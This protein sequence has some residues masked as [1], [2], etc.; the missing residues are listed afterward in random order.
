MSQNPPFE[1]Q[2]G[3]KWL[4]KALDPAGFQQVDLKGMPDQEAHNVVV[5]NYQSQFAV[6]PPAMYNAV[7]TDTSTYESEIYA[8]QDPVVFGV[9]AS[10][11]TGT[12]DPLHDDR[13]ISVKF[14]CQKSGAKS[15]PSITFNST[16]TLF[17]RTC[18][19]FVN[20]QISGDTKAGN[21]YEAFKGFAQ[22]HRVIY[23]ALQAIP[24]CSSQ[25]NS[26]TISVSQQPF[27]GDDLNKQNEEGVGYTCPPNATKAQ[28]TNA[29]EEWG[30]NTYG[31]RIYGKEDFPDTE[32]NI[33]NPASLLTRFAEGAYVPYKLKNPFS[34]DFITSAD[35]TTSIA[36]YWVVGAAYQPITSS[37]DSEAFVPMDWDNTAQCFTS[38]VDPNTG[39]R[40]Q[41]I[42][43]R[44]KLTLMS[45]TGSVKDIIFA[46]LDPT[47]VN[48]NVASLG[49]YT[50]GLNLDQTK[51]VLTNAQTYNP[52]NSV[53]ADCNSRDLTELQFWVDGSPQ[54]DGSSNDVTYCGV[55]R[56]GEDGMPRSR[57]PFSNVAAVLCKS[58][59]MK[60]N[61]TLLFRLGVEIVVTGN[62]VYSP[63]N[64]RSPS[65]DEAAIK[66]Y[67]KVV[68]RLSD[69]FYGNAATD[70]FRE[71]FYN[72]I[73]SQLY[74]PDTSVDF[75]NRGSY[76]RGLVS[77]NQ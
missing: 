52:G 16:G 28:W 70:Q 37:G 47:A 69:G 11:P 48:A 20:T 65:Y 38:K 6:E 5:L 29:Y 9:A 62:S 15:A 32:D 18:K 54:V 50:I 19:K 59:N 17:P 12:V 27:I 73:I 41:V 74:D 61:I 35:A 40:I 25:D 72:Y 55:Y 34:E 46:N 56:C 63:F 58:M 31:V 44:I 71:A 42:C 2:D 75:A 8:F 60:G 23:G 24:T 76:W 3:Q 39:N 64:H 14:G 22:R 36:P 13:N 1:T 77:R 30:I 53:M 33:R 68:H 45:K 49:L 21:A 4:A 67:L 7:G 26:G 51:N 66:S 10:Y 57:L 43:K